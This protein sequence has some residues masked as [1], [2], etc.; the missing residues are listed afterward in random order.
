M[1]THCLPPVLSNV[2]PP[3]RRRLPCQ[4][5][6]SPLLRSSNPPP[7]LLHTG[8]TTKSQTLGDQH[9]LPPFDPTARSSPTLLYLPYMRA[10]APLGP[11]QK[12]GPP[13]LAVKIIYHSCQLTDMVINPDCQLT[14]HLYN[15][16]LSLSPEQDIITSSPLM[17]V[18]LP[19]SPLLIVRV[20]HS[21]S[22][23]CTLFPFWES[24]F[25]CLQNACGPYS[26]PPAHCFGWKF[27]I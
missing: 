6:T 25:Q 10:G 2:V 27:E 13:A 14:D 4:T 19:P 17:A 3:D 16:F 11:Y 7:S 15:A 12:L 24:C 23:C 26:C 20:P 18:A 21:P 5:W 1:W 9:P 8:I 22:H